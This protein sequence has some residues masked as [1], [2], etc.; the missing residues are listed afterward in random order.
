MVQVGLRPGGRLFFRPLTFTDSNFEELLPTDPIFTVSK[1]LNL[2]KKNFEN[3]KASYNFGLGFAW[4]N[5]SH[6]HSALY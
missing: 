2:L 1:D 6:F 5:R 3:Q 4:S